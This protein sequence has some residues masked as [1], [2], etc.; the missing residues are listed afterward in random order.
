MV[1]EGIRDYIS[2]QAVR[3]FVPRQA[4]WV[5]SVTPSNLLGTLPRA[6]G[7]AAGSVPHSSRTTLA[8]GNVSARQGGTGPIFASL[9]TV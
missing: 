7:P 9:L 2:P 5:W 4:L 1:K 6:S 3:E 8:R